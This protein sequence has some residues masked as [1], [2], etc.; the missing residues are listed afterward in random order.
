MLFIKFIKIDGKF[1]K[2]LQKKIFQSTK[3]NCNGFEF[4]IVLLITNALGQCKQHIT[5]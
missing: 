5:A 2:A 3:N 4:S 1:F